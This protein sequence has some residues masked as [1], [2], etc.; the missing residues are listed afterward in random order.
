MIAKNGAHTSRLLLLLYYYVLKILLAFLDLKMIEIS[1]AF[2]HT[3]GS[4][5]YAVH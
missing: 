3:I 4:R 2:L 1:S 5:I